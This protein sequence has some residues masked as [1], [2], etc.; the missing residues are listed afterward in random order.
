MRAL[1]TIATMASLGIALLMNAPVDT[2]AALVHG[3]GQAMLDQGEV[4]E[5]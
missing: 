4:D 2:Q 1:R 5:T 3:C